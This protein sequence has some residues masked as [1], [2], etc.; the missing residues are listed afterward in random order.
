MELN[1][2]PEETAT[3]IAER[4]G[5]LKELQSSNK[6][7]YQ[8]RVE[9]LKVLKSSGLDIGDEI[10]SSDLGVNVKI[11]QSRSTRLDRDL[12]MEYGVSGEVIDMATIIRTSKDHIRF[13]H[14]QN[15]KGLKMG[16]KTP[17]EED[18]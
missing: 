9:L 6:L 4:L 16:L 8:E 3:D 17:N 14:T 12:L 15:Q 5:R 11:V 1:E 7:Y 10:R 2:L 13:T 18:C